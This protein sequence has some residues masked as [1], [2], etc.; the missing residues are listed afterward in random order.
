MII[1]DPFRFAREQRVLDGCGGAAEFVRVAES[2]TNADLVLNWSLRGTT[3]TDRRARLLL[4]VSG[5]V[6]LQCQ[7]CLGDLVHPVDVRSLLALYRSDEA[8]P[9]D[10]LDND[11]EDA[12]QIAGDLDI[13]A[14]IEDEVLLAL[15]LAPC[16][17]D[18]D[19]PSA[20]ASDPSQSP[21]ALLAGLKGQAGRGGKR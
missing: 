19:L 21:F 13:V 20:D 1:A 4:S 10:E 17:Q 11:D 14:L 6:R 16:H 15:P 5:S 3:G 7:R 18:C 2:V 9:E 8:L 12:L